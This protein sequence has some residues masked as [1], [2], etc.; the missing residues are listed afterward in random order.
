MENWP[1]IDVL[2]IENGDSQSYVGLPEYNEK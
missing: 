2:P 1:C